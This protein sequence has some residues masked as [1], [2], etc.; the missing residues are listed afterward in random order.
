M[1]VGLRLREVLAVPAGALEELVPC[2]GHS[3]LELLSGDG[4]G[5]ALAGETA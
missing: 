5:G 4:T 2:F 1:W 3:L